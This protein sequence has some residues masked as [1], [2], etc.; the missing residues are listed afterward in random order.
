[1]VAVWLL[2]ASVLVPPVAKAAPVT[3][4]F[5]RGFSSEEM[6]RGLFVP[7]SF[8]FSPNGEVFV[9]EKRG[10]VKV[11]DSITSTTSRVAADLSRVVH[12]TAD[13]G[14]LGLAI[15]PQYPVRPYIWVAYTLNAPPGATAPFYPSDECPTPPGPNTDGCVVQGRLSKLTLDANDQLVSEQVLITDWCA[16]FSSH[17]VGDLRFGADGA[18]YMS[19]GDGASFNFADYGQAGTAGATAITPTATPRNACADPPGTLGSALTASTSMGGGF[20]AQ[21]FRRPAGLPVSLDGSVIRVNPDTGAALPDNPSAADP[22]PNRRR[23]V[24]YGFRNPYRMTVRPGTS[25]MWVNNVGASGREWISRIATPTAAPVLNAGWPCY[26]GNAVMPGY[27]AF[28]NGLCNT[29]YAVGHDR[30]YFDYPHNGNIVS[31]GPEAVNGTSCQQGSGAITGS[32]FYNGGTYGTAQPISNYPAEYDGALFFTD[33]TRR[34]FYAMLKGANGL[35]DPT[36][37]KIVGAEVNGNTDAGVVDM[38]VGPDGRIWWVDIASG[39]IFRLKYESN[40]VPVATITTSPSPA[41]IQPGQSVTFSSVGSNDPAGGTLTYS[42][43]LNGDGTFGDATTPTA[44]RTYTTP[45]DIPVRLRVTNTLGLSATT[46]TNVHV[47]ASTVTLQAPTTS[48]T[49][50]VGAP[51][52]FAATATD[53]SGAQLPASAFSWAVTIRHCPNFTCH[54]HELQSVSGVRSG[55]FIAPDHPYPSTLV[56]SASVTNNGVTDSASIEILPLTNSLTLQSN[57]P[58]L[59]LAVNEEAGPGP[60]TVTVI[61]GS[62]ASVTAPNQIVGLTDYTF[63]SWSDG[64]TQSHN[65]NVNADT[66]LTANFTGVPTTRL[67]AP[68]ALG[69][70]LNGAA[71]PVPGGVQ[72]TPITPNQA[73]SAFYSTAV[74]SGALRV[75]FDLEIAGGDGADGM[76]FTMADGSAPATSLGG[77]GGLLGYGGIPGTAVAFDTYRSTNDPSGN[78]VGISQGLTAGAV[79]WV[80]TNTTVPPLIGIK[81]RAVVTTD[82]GRLK[83]SIDGVQYLDQAVT[84]PPTVKLGFTGATGGLVNVHTVTNVAIETA[85]TT[86]PAPVLSVAPNPVGFGDVS[87]GSTGTRPLTLTNV[88]TA[89]LS[90]TS[91][92]APGAPFAATGLPATGTSIAPGAS[93]TANLAFTPTATGPYTGSVGVTSNGGSATVPLS[94]NG[95]AASSILPAP[96]SAGWQLNGAAAAVPGGVQLT[97]ATALTAGSTF[98]GTAVPSG[99]L[100]VDFDLTIAGGDGADGMT[101]TLADPTAPATSLGGTGGLLGFGGIPGTA[102]AFDTYQGTND[103]SANFVGLTNTNGAELSW[104]ASATTVPPLQG[105][106]RKVSITTGGGRLKVSI[107]GVQYLDQAVTLPPTV[108]VGFT[109]ATGGLTNVHTVSNVVVNTAAGTPTTP[110]LSV[111]PNP[112]AFGS[113]RVGTTATAFATISN[114]GTAPLTIS[115]TT[116]PAAPFAATGLPAPGTTIAPGSSVTANLTF[117]P[118]A[119]GAA[120]GTLGIVSNGGNATIPLSATGTI[121]QLSVS[122]N[123]VAFGSVT[124]GSTATTTVTISNTGSAPLTINATTAP[125]APFGATGLPAA[126][127]TI[128]PGAGVTAN[129]R[130][131][132]T[133]TT[134]TAGSLGIASNGGS[135]TLPLSG[136]GVA[137]SS[138]LPAPPGAG[139]QLNGAATAVIGGIRLTPATASVAGSTFY[140][141]AVPSGNLKVDFDLNISGGTG[142]D[143]ATFAL[144][145]GAAP[146]TSLGGTGGR[147]GFGGIGGT[148]VAF[149]TYK[150]ANDPSANHVGITQTTSGSL[151]WLATATNVPPLTGSTRKVS[152]TTGGGRMKV[153]IDGVQYLDQAVTLPP[154]VKVGFTAA[155]GGQTNIHT[156]SNV[157]VNT[158]AGPPTP[159]AVLSVTPNPVSFGGVRVG[160]T[161]TVFATI[162]NTGTAPLTISSTTAPSAPFGASALPAAGTTIAPGSSVTANLT[163]SPTVAGAASGSFGIVSNGGNATIPLAGT[164]TTAQLAVSPNPVAFGSVAVGTTATRAVTVSNTG[165]AP[166]TISSTT[167]PAAPFGVSGLPATGTTVAPGASVAASVTYTPTTATTSS[168]TLTVASTGG[169]VA[170]P[171]SGTGTT[172]GAQL[173]PTSTASAWQVNAN[174]TRTA[175]GV[176]LTPAVATQRGSV[177]STQTISSASITAEF[178]LNISGG[179]AADGLTFALAAPTVAATAVGGGGGLL[180]WGGLAGTAVAFDTYKGSTDPS[181]NFVGITSGLAAGRLA[182]TSVNT[183]VPPLRGVTRRVVV[184]V[185]GGRMTVSIDGVQYLDQAVTLP[186]T[187]RPGFTAATGGQFD[188]HAISNVVVRYG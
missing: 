40:D 93:V 87:V 139:W 170:V 147:L 32:A 14:L 20:R 73:G 21:S 142:A 144:I 166:L 12:N 146:A 30:P 29:L 22:D 183:A 80:A 161:A 110:I 184:T 44:Q 76:T 168:G 181:A 182:Y 64:G 131:C 127:T 9:A 61:R 163:Y 43:D 106:T 55:Q 121:P 37:V 75:E 114:T 54:T 115:S 65:V 10:T 36:Q 143:G 51:V 85:A 16:Q 113:V 119:A 130:R 72:L 71:T 104:L 108:K 27:Q 123:P 133:A 95:I 129:A 158:A 107:D 164:G 88:G 122:P 116:A 31:S 35:P 169:T 15:D 34:C 41:S 117:T 109:A 26:E 81:R 112:V 186:A 134:A 157:V 4:Q 19:G 132:P 155:T 28:D 137:S 68:P 67:P 11:F 24:G 97:P 136:T 53:A 7:T 92:S 99:N 176:L 105:T 82:G 103:P 154:T 150:G 52:N 50:S 128:A 100:K 70:Q 6:L 18:L 126:G 60:R 173:P 17:T 56:V 74:P 162:A 49:W 42:W 160:T 149:D 98:Y 2:V 5:L 171:V 145:D 1:M 77:T 152:V 125:S 141:T 89:P 140:G 83:V 102:V 48:T 39:K 156:V 159:S 151:T 91:T 47:A 120:A 124:V 179:N 33:F 25:E 66:T 46:Q 165:T 23:I 78:F 94:G 38:N 188:N 59:N 8:R 135:V 148:A 172:S 174:A 178:D 118:T 177:F 185:A 96:P 45:G 153:S 111:T 13:R 79:S 62:A 69:W 138:V 101:F 58:G 63:S 90:I 84:L 175:S 187:V 57:P 180:G 167:A 3:A 86:S